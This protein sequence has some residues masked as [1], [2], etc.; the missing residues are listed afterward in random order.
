MKP[1]AAS[2]LGLSLLAGSAAAQPVDLTVDQ[3]ASS[4][5]VEVTA[6]IS[7]VSLPASDSSPLAGSI[8]I[9]LDDYGV[10]TSILLHDFQVNATETLVLNF[11]AGFL[12]NA[13]ATLENAG[14]EYAGTLPAGPGA[15]DAGGVFVLENVPLE[16]SGSG[17]TTGSGVFADFGGNTFDLQDFG[18]LEGELSGTVEIV[19]DEVVLDISIVGSGTQTQDGVTLDGTA[20]IRIV[21]RGDVPVVVVC[22][23]DIADDF[24]FTAADGGGPDG[25]VDFGD[26][27]ALLGL[28]GP[29]DGGTPGCIGDI[30]DDFG[31]TALDGGGPDGVVDFGDFVALLGLIGPCE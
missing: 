2:V 6:S 5:L 24:G 26:F 20:T 1:I 8:Q 9:Q 19:G 11:N 7:F 12:G 13:T 23:G 28:I 17:S 3:G 18:V 4:L 15:V 25:V 14:A 10:P 16:L 31:F 27:V 22:L 29:C 30:A 21:A